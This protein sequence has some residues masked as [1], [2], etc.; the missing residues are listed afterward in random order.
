M[1]EGWRKLNLGAGQDIRANYLNVD[2][3]PLPG[4]DVIHDLNNLPLPFQDSSFDEI[5]CN[6]ILEH[7]DYVPL[8]RELHRILTPGG[9][10]IVHAPHF[11][12][13]MRYVDPTHKHA[14]SIDTFEFFI[15][16]GK[17]RQRSYYFDFHFSF[18]EEARITF[19]RYRFEPWNYIVEPIVNLNW[20]TQEFYES[21][22]LA[23]IF[24][25][26]DIRVVLVK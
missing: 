16:S 17:F 26:A 18:I 25:A 21:T 4:V 8:M 14:F 5:L 22:L 20:K 15:D 19:H 23:R 11:T 10:L 1:S 3:K 13:R 24:P 6:D 2:F 7:L 12:S 9:K